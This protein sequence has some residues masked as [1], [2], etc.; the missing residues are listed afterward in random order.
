MRIVFEF[1]PSNDHPYREIRC[2]MEDDGSE[3]GKYIR[4]LTPG[5]IV[6]GLENPKWLT[7]ADPVE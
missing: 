2:L 6:D 3:K 4:N 7:E 1:A 5:E